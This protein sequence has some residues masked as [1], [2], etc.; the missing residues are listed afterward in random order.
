MRHHEATI[1]RRWRKNVM[2]GALVLMGLTGLALPH[3][4][5][6]FRNSGARVQTHRSRTST[7]TP[8]VPAIRPGPPSY[9]PDNDVGYPS[10]PVGGETDRSVSDQKGGLPYGIAAT[11]LPW[12]RPGFEEYEEPSRTP[13]DASL[14]PPAKYS[15]EATALPRETPISVP[16]ASVLIA[17][18]PE[19]GLLWVE[20]VRTRL[21][22][23]TRTFQS[24]LLQPGRNY[25]YTVRVAWIEDGHWVDQTRTVPIRAGS[26]QALFLRKA[27]VSPVNNKG[28]PE[29]MPAKET[30]AAIK[31]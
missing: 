25:S 13:N 14:S 23:R 21:T 3:C 4:R 9:F 11:A 28:E 26:I 24:P 12:N 31:K 29:A 19:H 20:G 7:T 1:E 16:S 15:L 27:L 22:G 10:S 30:R 17:H 6:E 2:S 18:L 5:A 8:A